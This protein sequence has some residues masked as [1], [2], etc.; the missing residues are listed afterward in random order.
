MENQ[1]IMSFDIG[2]KNMAYC[3]FET[4]ISG[5]PFHIHDWN[6]LNL[7]EKEEPHVFCNCSAI[8]E[9]SLK[10][11][12]KMSKKKNIVVLEI[13]DS[14]LNSFL[15]KG[16]ETLC[17]KPAKF[18]KG[19]S[20]FCEKHAKSQTNYIVPIKKISISQLKKQKID[21]LLKIKEEYH[22]LDGETEKQKQ[23]K[24]TTLETLETFFTIHCFISLSFISIILRLSS[25][26]MNK[27]YMRMKLCR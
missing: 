21:D 16:N 3:I 13:V 18:K 8:K 6:V 1:R 27:R 26:D 12:P 23:T 7:M 22:V 19:D 24:K 11:V 14:S 2:I 9:R 20:F 17:G 15:K 5:S 25:F 10:K 4:D